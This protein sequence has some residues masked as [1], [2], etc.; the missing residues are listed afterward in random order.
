VGDELNIIAFRSLQDFWNKQSDGRL[1]PGGETGG[2][3][4]MEA[5]ELAM[6]LEPSKKYT[7]LELGCGNGDLYSEMRPFYSSYVGVDFSASNLKKFS[8]KYPDSHLICSDVLKFETEQKFDLLHSN[9]LVQYLTVGQ[10][11]LM[12]KKLLAMCAEG[13]IIVHR[14]F[15]DKRLIRLYF[16]GY[17]Y[18]GINRYKMQRL[19]YPLGYWLLEFFNRLTGTYNHLGYWHTRDEILDLHRSLGVEAEIFNS[20]L[21]PNRFNIV[22]RR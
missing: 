21:H 12:Q 15:L 11:E 4:R 10:L 14:G 2:N 7:C 16:I 13:G 22:I 8:E 1:G 3:Y 18:P 5:K 17:L 20:P 19:L 9:H 6:F